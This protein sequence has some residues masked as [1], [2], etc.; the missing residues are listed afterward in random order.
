MTFDRREWCHITRT[1]IAR[2]QTSKQVT[3]RRLQFFYFQ[4]TFYNKTGIE[5]FKPNVLVFHDLSHLCF[6]KKFKK[7]NYAQ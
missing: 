2:R 3:S 5:K 6:L 1:F 4:M 7:I